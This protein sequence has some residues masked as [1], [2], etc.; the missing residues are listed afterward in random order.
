MTVLSSYEAWAG[1]HALASH[2]GWWQGLIIAVV[3]TAVRVLYRQEAERARRR[4][5]EMLVEKASAGTMVWQDKGS[6]GPA[7]TVWIG[8]GHPPHQGGSS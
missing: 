3:G 7:V 4:T 6:G 1:L 8:A 2:V 5:L